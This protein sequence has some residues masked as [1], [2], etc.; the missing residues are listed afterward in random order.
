MDLFSEISRLLHRFLHFLDN[1]SY[2][3]ATCSFKRLYEQKPIVDH[4]SAKFRGAYTP[5]CDVERTFFLS[6][7]VYIP[8]KYTRFG[9]MLFQLCETC[10]VCATG[11][12]NIVS[13]DITV[14]MMI[15]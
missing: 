4:L 13:G 12:N 14:V 5:E 8:S 11:V 10:E 6:W 7:K 9:T 15:S 3:K 2:N 1:V